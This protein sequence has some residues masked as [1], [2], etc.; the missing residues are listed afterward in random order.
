MNFMQK[1]VA[2]RKADIRSQGSADSAQDT[3][4]FS[5]LVEASE[6]EEGK[7][8]LDDSELVSGSFTIFNDFWLIPAHSLLGRQCVHYAFGRAW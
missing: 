1:Q 4:A 2:E 8:K 7:F 3:N 6:N 5:M